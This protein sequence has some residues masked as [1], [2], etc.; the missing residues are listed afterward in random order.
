[1]FVVLLVIV[2]FFG[3]KR[4]PNAVLV[5]IT[6]LP[7]IVFFVYMLVIAENLSFW[8]RIFSQS[9]LD[10]GLGTRIGIWTLA[11]ESIGECFF[12]G[13]Y[14]KYYNTQMHNS[15]MTVFC[16][17]GAP[18]T[19]LTCVS[20]YRALRELQNRSSLVALISLSAIL[21]TGCFEASVFVG[22]AGLYLMV[23]LL[24]ACASVEDVDPS[25]PARM[26]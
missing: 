2:K 26:G 18:V 13:N 4:V 1:M 15:L 14:Y 17:F 20:I 23:L 19:V 7:L 25:T 12:L 11:Y 21:F 8:A 3:I 9:L 22:V 10:K 24:P 6:V 5:I 16:R